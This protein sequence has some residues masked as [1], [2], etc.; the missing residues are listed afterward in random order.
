MCVIKKE[1]VSLL[2][3]NNFPVVMFIVNSYLPQ[4]TNSS[5]PHKRPAENTLCGQPHGLFTH[6]EAFAHSPTPWQKKTDINPLYAFSQE[7]APS[8][9]RTDEYHSLK[10][11]KTGNYK[12]TSRILG[13]ICFL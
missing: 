6:I 10:L 7:L 3:K 2:L 12:M 4:E 8:I 13:R 5:Q 1:S 11:I 9:Q